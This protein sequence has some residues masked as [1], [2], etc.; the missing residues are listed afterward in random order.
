MT[1]S[2]FATDR[3]CLLRGALPPMLLAQV[4][5][6]AAPLVR[7]SGRGE[8]RET[9]GIAEGSSSWYGHKPLDGILDFLRPAF[10]RAIGEPLLPTYSFIRCYPRGTRLIRHR[11][12]QA[13]EVSV[14]LPIAG[15]DGTPWP[16]HLGLRHKAL[17]APDMALG[18]A[19]IYSG[20]EL[21]HWR[22]PLAAD[23]RL[24]LFLHYVRR[25]GRY[26]EWKFDKR[27]RLGDPPV[28]GTGSV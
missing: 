15:S 12:R 24:Q 18:D 23:W 14:T 1:S 19:L 3:Y 10:E 20:C 16:I 2:T 21:W 25:D 8:M 7:Q 28:A 5:E 6:V 9:D 22:E 13:C 26:A 11:D 4:A 17:A 27:E